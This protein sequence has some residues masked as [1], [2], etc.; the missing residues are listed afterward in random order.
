M[1]TSTPAYNSN[2]A[3]TLVVSTLLLALTACTQQ[4]P[5]KLYPVRGVIMKVDVAGKSAAIDAEKIEGWMEAMTMDY[6]VHDAKLLDGL[7]PGDHITAIVHVP[8]DL[9][10]WIDG[11]QKK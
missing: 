10:Y 11:I 3:R 9:N 6:P 8:E 7:K 2:V 4:K 1:L 5:A